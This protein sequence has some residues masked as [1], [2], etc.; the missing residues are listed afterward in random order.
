[1]SSNEWEQGLAYVKKLREDL[2]TDDEIRQIMLEV[3]WEEEQIEQLVTLT[4]RD[5]TTCPRG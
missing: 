1:M 3:G 5:P 2:H 4:A